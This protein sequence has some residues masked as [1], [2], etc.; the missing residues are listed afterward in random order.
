MKKNILILS[1]IFSLLGFIRSFFFVF[2][3]FDDVT[4][5]INLSLFSS[6][7]VIQDWKFTFLDT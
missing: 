7:P 6:Q 2:Y 1:L 3:D 5:F 4:E